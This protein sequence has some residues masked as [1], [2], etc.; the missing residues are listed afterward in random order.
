MAGGERRGFAAAA[1][2]AIFASLPR[3]DPNQNRNTSLA[4]DGRRANALRYLDVN[5]TMNQVVRCEYWVF[6]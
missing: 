4:M 1:R 2:A 5:A 3:L 6:R